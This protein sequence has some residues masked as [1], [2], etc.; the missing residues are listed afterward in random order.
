MGV[1]NC[2]KLLRIKK[3]EMWIRLKWTELQF[4]WQKTLFVIQS[5]DLILSCDVFH[6]HIVYYL[7]LCQFTWEKILLT[8]SGDVR[9]CINS[10]WIYSFYYS[11]LAM[12]QMAHLALWRIEITVLY[13]ALWFGIVA[14]FLFCSLIKLLSE[15]NI[16][17]H[18]TL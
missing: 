12:V 9:I 6:F 16:I 5:M 18:F 13:F 8:L 11:T 4:S 1:R 7:S 17:I 3:K 2:L 14:V 15:H 10:F